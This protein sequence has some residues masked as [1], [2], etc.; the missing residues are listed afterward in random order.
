L[1]RHPTDFPLW[2]DFDKKHPKF[3]ADSCNICLAFAADGFNS[4]RT[5]NV[6]YSI[7]PDILIPLNFSPSMC[8]KDSNFI[9]FVLIPGRAPAGTDMDIYF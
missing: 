8:M 9:L 4:Y 5:M 7:W 3:A 2:K 6:S 1:L